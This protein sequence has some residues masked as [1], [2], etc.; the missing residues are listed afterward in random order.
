LRV[1]RLAAVRV[2][3]PAFGPAIV[4]FLSSFPAERSSSL[5]PSSRVGRLNDVNEQQTGAEIVTPAMFGDGWT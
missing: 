4:E 2:I 3:F 1:Q 5:V